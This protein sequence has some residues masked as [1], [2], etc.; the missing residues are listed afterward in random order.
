MSTIEAVVV[1]FVFAL[2][3]CFCTLL[4]IS[5]Y[6]YNKTVTGGGGLTPCHEGEGEGE[7]VAWP[8]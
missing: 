8:S 2:Y 4:Q 7:M 1:F 5:L 6:F 3:Y